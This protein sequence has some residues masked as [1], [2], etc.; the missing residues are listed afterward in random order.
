MTAGDMAAPC[1]RDRV[2]DT[3]QLAPERPRPLRRTEYEHLV[4]AG[5]FVDERIELLEGVLV[6]MSPQGAEHADVVSRLNMLFV[7]LVGD[8]AVVRVQSPFAASDDSEPEPD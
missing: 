2:L 7:R 3:A 1:Y 5:A 8:R 4:E 6:Q